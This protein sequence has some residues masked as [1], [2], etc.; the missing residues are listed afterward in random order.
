MAKKMG[1]YCKAYPLTMLR[2]FRGWTENVQNVRKE[3]Q[4]VDGEET[5]VDRTLTDDDFLYLQE[6]YT[7][8]DDI[9]MDENVIFAHVTPEW[10]DFCQ[11]TLQF[12]IPVYQP[13][14][15]Q[16]LEEEDKTDNSQA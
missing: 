13:R 3:K 6:D 12:E 4:Y 14:E 8:T 9:F 15:I 1:K 7:V 16:I 5:D 10:R 2:E 11:H